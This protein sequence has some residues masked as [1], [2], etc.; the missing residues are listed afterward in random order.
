MRRPER[1][2]LLLILPGLA[3]VLYG[4]VQFALGRAE[5]AR[6]ARWP[7]VQGAILS[8]G[9]EIVDF[10]TKY[11]DG[12]YWRPVLRYRYS[13]AGTAY[14][15]KTAWLGWH[16]RMQSEAEANAFLADFPEG[17]A[18]TVRYDPADPARSA[19]FAAVD[20]GWVLALLIP[21]LV[22]LVAATLVCWVVWTTPDRRA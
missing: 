8:A 4:A 5:V 13:V 10:R 7:E 12:W 21:G 22:V 11:G 16:P 17:L 9:H 19:L 2:A 18:V 6:F 14:K 3:L 15:G 1:L 20:Y